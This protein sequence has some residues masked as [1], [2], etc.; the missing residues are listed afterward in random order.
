MQC[1]T[2]IAYCLTVPVLLGNAQRSACY[3]E[4]GVK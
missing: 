1:P 4:L 2:C 3:L